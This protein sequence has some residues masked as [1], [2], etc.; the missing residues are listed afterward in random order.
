[1]TADFPLH[2][3][4]LLPFIGAAIALV[5]GRRLGNN[6]VTLLCCGSV[7]GA[8]LVTVKGVWTLHQDLPPSAALVGHFFDA[9][10]MKAGELTINSGLVMDH[11]AAVLC[12]VVTGIGLLIHIYSTAYMEHDERYTR[13]FAFLNLFT[14]SMLVLVLGD[15]LPVTFVGWEGVGLCSYLLIGFW[16]DKDANALAGRKAFVVN[17]IGDF[18]FLLAM[19]II[20]SKTGTLKYSELPR[21]ADQL[22]AITWLGL[23]AAYFIGLLVLLGATGK[24]AQIPLYIWLPDAMAGPTPVSALIHAATMV[25]AGVYVVARM[26][27]VF[28]IAPVTLA[29]VAV[30][31]AATALFA[32]T[33]G[34]AQRDLKKV[35]A[36]STISQLGFM[37]VGVGTYIAGTRT[38]NYQAGIFHLVTHAFFKAGL[39]LAAGSVLHGLANEGDIMRMGGLKK[40]MPHT[41]W[42]FLIYCFAIAGIFPFAGFWS[43]DAI[44]GGLIDAKWPTSGPPSNWFEHYFF[45]PGTE[46]G[47]FVINLGHWLYPVLLLAAAFT[48]FYM[49]RLYFLVFEGEY[50]G[51]SGVV[52]THGDDDAH[53]HAHDDHHHDDHGHGPAHES[54]PAMTVVLWILAAGSLLVGLLGIPDVVWPGRDL[55]G[56]WLAPVLPPLAHEENVGMFATFALIAL[57]VSLLGIGF[58]WLLYGDG[59]SPRVKKFVATFPWLY[60]LVFNKFYIDEVYDFLVVRPVR[61]VAV[62]L[63]KAFD[64]VI[65]DLIFVNGTGFIVSG[66]G[67]LSKYFQNGDLQRYIVAVIVGG[68]VIIGVGTHFDVW[69]GAKFD[70]TIEGR[71]VQVVAH[72]A[73]P[74]AKRLQYRVDWN[75][76]GKFSTTQMATTFKHTYDAAGT[77]KISVEAIDPRWGTVSRESRT[78]KVQ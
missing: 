66:F 54:P 24:S 1:M 15:S 78:V 8:F 27:F 77:H 33:I 13:F 9:P 60:K 50:R 55:F 37:F 71:D 42:T 23:P 52:E 35:L 39:F 19:F 40:W 47:Q 74:T 29:A 2:L 20:Y 46:P 75:G 76:D 7:G 22:H 45:I 30:I 3:I 68:A 57:G 73:G 53:A 11:L 16:L 28:E 32:A 36:Y 70:A 48:A 31:G 59:V 12:L 34:I 67:K 49:F 58:A 69:S 65:I 4:P 62:A 10:W 63:W 56:E 5:L 51:G 44:L 64:T 43:K 14:G 38:S 6:I 17:R 61:F 26:H 41:R 25:T 72:G 21:Y 18:G